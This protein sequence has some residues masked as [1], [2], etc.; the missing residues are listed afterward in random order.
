MTHQDH[1]EA[2]ATGTELGVQFRPLT[3]VDLH[4]LS[5]LYTRAEDYLVLAEGRAPD[6]AMVQAFFTDCV[7]GGC[8]AQSVKL[9]ADVGGRLIGVADMCFAYPLERDA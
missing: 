9:G 2:T 5:D 3:R 4:L 1:S 7:P 6:V 8:V